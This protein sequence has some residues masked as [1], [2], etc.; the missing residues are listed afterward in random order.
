M[1]K[2]YV[3]DGD[4]VLK[5]YAPGIVVALA[6][7]VEQ[8][9]EYVIEELTEGDDSPFGWMFGSL[10]DSEEQKE[11]WK[12]SMSWIDAPP[13]VIDPSHVALPQVFYRM[14]GE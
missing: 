4:D 9:R 7:S 13:K 2:L 12:N 5:N 6:D 10:W 1:K 14:G 11:H 8:A 3:W